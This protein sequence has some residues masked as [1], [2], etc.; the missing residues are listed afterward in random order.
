MSINANIMTTSDIAVDIE[1]IVAVE[2]IPTGV[3]KIKKSKIVNFTINEYVQEFISSIVIDGSTQN[4]D[5]IELWKGKENQDKLQL[6]INQR[7]IKVKRAPKDGDEPRKPDSAFMLFSSEEKIKILA[8]NPD[9]EYEELTPLLAK[10]WQELKLNEE[11]VAIYQQRALEDKKRYDDE[12]NRYKMAKLKQEK[13]E[14]LEKRLNKMKDRNEEKVQKAMSRPKSAYFFFKNDEQ[15]KIKGENDN[16]T[17]KEMHLE[18][19]KRWKG[20]KTTDPEAFDHYKKIAEEKE[21]ENPAPVIQEKPYKVKKTNLTSED[22]PYKVKKTNLITSENKPYKINKFNPTAS[23][24]NPSTSEDK[25]YK[26]NPTR[27]DTP[28]KFNHT[29]ED[30]PSKI[31]G[32]ASIMPPRIKKEEPKGVKA[33][34]KTKYNN[35][36]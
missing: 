8:E 6:F 28:Y 27:E 16:I 20:L 31:M 33:K 34:N 35:R 7:K 26:F 3:V 11:S 14:K 2:S 32:I 18:L 22:K 13:Q 25:T 10:K 4:V 1:S 21:N 5:I 29:A 12:L 36:K 24:F 9:I 30:K 15:V 19:Q 23:E 17:K